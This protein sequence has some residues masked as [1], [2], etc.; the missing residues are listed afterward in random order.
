MKRRFQTEL[1]QV[2]VC[3]TPLLISNE[4]ETLPSYWMVE[5]TEDLTDLV[6]LEN[7]YLAK[8]RV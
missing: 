3:Y 6:G 5:I 4:S 1:E 2:S 8:S 7:I